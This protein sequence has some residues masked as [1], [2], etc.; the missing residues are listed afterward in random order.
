MPMSRP[1]A[2][3]MPAV[4]VSVRPKGWPSAST[5]S[6]ICIASL[7][8]SFAAG[9]ELVGLDLDDRDVGVRIGLHFGRDELAAV[10]QPDRDLAAAGDDVVIRQND[11]SRRR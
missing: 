9:S 11:A 10:V 1:L 6:P 7:S 2:L 5:Q 4:T 3:T 8:P